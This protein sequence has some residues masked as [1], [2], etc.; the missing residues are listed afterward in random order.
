[1]ITKKHFIVSVLIILCIVIAV[2]PY[3]TSSQT[4]TGD[5]PEYDPW[6]DINDDGKINIYDV[7]KVCARYGAK[8]TPIIKAS[9]TNDTGWLDITDKAGQYFNITHNL[10]ST[11]IIVD[12][13]GKTTPDGGVHQRN[14]GGTGY[15]TGWWRTY[16]KTGYENAHS[17]VQTVGGGYAIAGYTESLGAGSQDF[18]LVKTDWTGSEEWNRTYGGLNS[19]EARDVVHTADVGFALA[20]NTQSKGAGSTDFW[21][22]KTDLW[23]NLQ[24]DEPYGGTNMDDCYCVIQTSD[25]GYALTGE[26]WSFGAGMNDLW[27]V[28]T[29]ASGK[30]EWNRPYGGSNID[31]GKSV[32]ETDDGGYVIA[33]YT[34]SFG[35]GSYD[36]WLIRTNATGY[37]QWNK[38]YG[39]FNDDRCESL[40]KTSDGGYAL[41]GFTSSMGAGGRDFWLVKTDSAG[42]EQWNKTYGGTDDDN[43]LSLLQT[44]D[45]GYALAGITQSF[46]SGTHDCWLVKTD[47]SGDIQWKRTYGGTNSDF[48]YYGLVRTSDGGFAICGDTQSFGASSYDIWLIKTDTEFGLAWTDSTADTITLYRGATDPYWNY[49]RV[50]IW[51]IKE[52]P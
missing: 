29:N 35:A 48:A 36:F 15:I 23:G 43:A 52:T 39:G 34:K 24:W 4:Q 7:V 30:A 28:K 38:T 50:R 6:C 13:T 1:M 26:T 49:V 44:L 10:N 27:L 32:V 18:W 11:D 3:I 42:N 16:G 46:G 5:E 8:G 41:A 20:G 2:Y 40:V 37:P 31:I 45:G 33:G 9:I 21:L 19:D 17:L 47:S 25:G 51:K 14:L 22:V 12:I